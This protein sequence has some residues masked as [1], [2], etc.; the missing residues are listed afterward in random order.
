MQ[1]RVRLR[2][3][4]MAS[5]HISTETAT[6]IEECIAAA[7]A[8]LAANPPTGRRVRLGF[9]IVLDYPTNA[10]EEEKWRDAMRELGDD[11]V[12]RMWARLALAFPD[13][14]E[15]RV[16]SHGHSRNAAR[17]DVILFA[18]WGDA[19][20]TA[21][22]HPG[23]QRRETRRVALAAKMKEECDKKGWKICHCGV[24]AHVAKTETQ[25]QEEQELWCRVKHECDF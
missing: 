11:A 10:A 13:R 19:D 14:V 18:D 17:I 22:A 2:N 20:F 23:A 6:W 16:T 1:R 5:L 8:H 12:V 4:T 7:G 9:G 21:P 24:N 25:K 15:L 3:E